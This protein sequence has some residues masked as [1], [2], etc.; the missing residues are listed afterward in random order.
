M[1]VLR[2]ETEFKKT[3]IGEIPKDW[4]VKELGRVIKINKKSRNANKEPV[5]FISMENIPEDGLHPK[6][7]VKNPNEVKSGIEVFPGSLLLAKITPS[8]EHG[9]SCI[10]P[11][12]NNYKW[13]ATTEV[14]SIL[15]KDDMVDLLYLFYFFKFPAIREGLQYTMTGT[16]GRQRVPKDALVQLEIPYPPL[17]EQTRIATVL[18]W[19]DDLIE[20]KRK[21]NEILEKMAMAIFKSW[22][23]DFEP[24]QDEEF[25][26]S[27]E[28]DMEIPKG[29]E[30]KKLNSIIEFKYGK[31]LP[32]RK[33]EP[34][35]YPVVGSSG[36]VGYHSEYLVKGPTVIIGRKGNVGTVQLIA[37]PNYPID[38]VFYSAPNTPKELVFYIYHYLKLNSPKEVASTDT[39]VPGLNINLLNLMDIIIPPQPILQR[40]HS[41]VE[42]L[43]QKILLNQKQI[44]TLK[45]IRDTLLPQLVFGRL[46]V[47]KL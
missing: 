32:E 45:K 42:P 39:A 12:G 18:S 34:G 20:N 23:I 16:S 46:R 40:F 41:L 25:V 29:W 9:K 13:V 17:Q 3:E 21:Q 4:E 27:E 30:V 31:G 38:T 47:E 10:V 15:P 36:I 44:L 26:Y 11:K 2:W 35:P 7:E 5:A 43:F 37:E 8:F 28:L 24:F 19:F 1:V 22:F 14:F 33:R 6:F